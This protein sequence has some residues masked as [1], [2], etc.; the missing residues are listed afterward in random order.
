MDIDNHIRLALAK[1]HPEVSRFSYPLFAADK[2]DYP[3]LYASSVLM[4]YNRKSLLITS[5]HAIWEI[6]KTGSAVYLGAN[7]IIEL[8]E[9]FP[10]ISYR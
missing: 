9:K 4:E 3:D 1:L 10:D 7:E 8:P 6:K 5:G 2:R